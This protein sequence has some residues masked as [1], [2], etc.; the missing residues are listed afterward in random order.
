MQ[1]ALLNH[2]LWER[3][4]KN[5]QHFVRALDAQAVVLETAIEGAQ[6]EHPDIARLPGTHLQ[7]AAAEAISLAVSSRCDAIIV[8]DINFGSNSNKGAGQDPWIAAFPDSL[9]KHF[10][11]LPPII[12]VPAHNDLSPA[13]LETFVYHQF[14]NMASDTASLRRAWSRCKNY[15]L[16]KQQPLQLK[17]ARQGKSYTAII[18]QAWYFSSD[19]KEALRRH[20]EDVVF[21]DEWD[22]SSLSQL[23]LRLED[24][25]IRSDS[26]ALGAGRFLSNKGVV[27]K[28]ICLVDD[29]SGSD[30]WLLKRL[31]K[32]VHKGVEALSLQTL[33][34]NTSL[35]D[36]L[37][38]Q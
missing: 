8:P 35:Q 5:W 34:S 14:I 36:T 28:I 33:L 21:Q 10:P 18:G 16:S 9:A 29:V 1:I 4:G 7:R 17:N 6:L 37:Q 13:E 24:K 3:C 19:V 38:A 2:F 30:L 23:G 25:L 32:H 26:E 15:F 11:F 22:S 12:G 27:S 31:N 20:Y